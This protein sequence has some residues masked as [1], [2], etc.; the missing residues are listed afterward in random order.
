[1][2]I[3]IAKALKLKNR[4]Q[5]RIRALSND[6]AAYNSRLA[7]SG[8]EVNVLTSLDEYDR[9]V[10]SLVQLKAKIF[11]SN[12]PVYEKILRL[13][14]AKSKIKVLR[15]FDTQHGKV[16]DRYSSIEPLEYYAQLRK[17]DIDTKCRTLEGTIDQLQEE[18]DSHNHTTFIEIDS[19]DE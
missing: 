3:T 4:I 18:L 14:E 6:M 11:A 19:I 2:K 5:S 13:A 9:L 10:G 17:S 1:M 12:A 15:S 7:G 16:A 8:S